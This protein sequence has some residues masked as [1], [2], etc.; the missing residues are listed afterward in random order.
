MSA[1]V[2]ST[3]PKLSIFITSLRGTGTINPS[4]WLQKWKHR[5]LSCFTHGHTAQAGW[6]SLCSTSCSVAHAQGALVLCS[7]LAPEREKCHL[8]SRPLGPLRDPRD[9]LQASRVQTSCSPQ[10]ETAEGGGR[11]KAEASRLLPP[12]TR[13]H[14]DRL[15]QCWAEMPR[16]SMAT[17][18]HLWKGRGQEEQ[19]A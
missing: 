19:E 4:S 6:F 14:G 9:V 1:P 13:P 12:V 15:W 18:V 7:G 2:L 17:S 5:E 3:L 10:P 8:G 11:T 16:S